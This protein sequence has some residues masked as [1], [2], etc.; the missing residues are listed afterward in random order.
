M[1]PGQK[2]Q[3]GDP[4]GQVGKFVFEIIHGSFPLLDITS[5]IN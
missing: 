1:V 3:A 5:L 4:L 2:T